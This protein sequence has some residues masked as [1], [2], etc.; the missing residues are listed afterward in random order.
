LSSCA[1]WTYEPHKDSVIKQFEQFKDSLDEERLTLILRQVAGGTNFYNHS[2]YDLRRLAQDSKNIAL[3]FNKYLNGYSKNVL[4]IIE[5][6]Q[7]E[8]IITKLVKNDLFYQLA[9]MLTEVDLSPNRVTNHEMGY[10]FEELLRRFSKMSIEIIEDV[11][12]DYIL[13]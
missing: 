1:V 10:I 13:R 11:A 6:F 7:L 4:K 2:L 8:K 3:N 12:W 9:E 5:N